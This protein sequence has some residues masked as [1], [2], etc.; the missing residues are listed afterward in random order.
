MEFFL[1]F[2]SLTYILYKNLSDTSLNIKS[3]L[4]KVIKSAVSISP[5]KS[6]SKILKSISLAYLLGF[7]SRPF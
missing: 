6:S 5:S 3:N 1:F 4:F 2:I 7:N